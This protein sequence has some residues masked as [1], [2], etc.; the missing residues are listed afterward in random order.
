MRPVDLSFSHRREGFRVGAQRTE[1]MTAMEAGEN[2]GGEV[3]VH[4]H[5][6][7]RAR[8]RTDNV[9]SAR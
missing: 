4:L 2:Q 5:T 6:R 8:A 3:I 9:A 1:S 7:R